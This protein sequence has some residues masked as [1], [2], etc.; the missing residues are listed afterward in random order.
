MGGQKWARRSW[1]PAALRQ[2]RLGLH[3]CFKTKMFGGGRS[4]T[5]TKRKGL[6]KEGAC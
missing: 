3:Q 5:N 4:L 2:G 6:L 1:L